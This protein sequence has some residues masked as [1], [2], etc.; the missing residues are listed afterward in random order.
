M[1]S[2]WGHI[3]VLCT[4]LCYNYCW[5]LQP[6]VQQRC[7]FSW[8]IKAY[9]GCDWDEFAATSHQNLVNPQ[10]PVVCK[11]YVIICESWS[12]L[13]VMITNLISAVPQGVFYLGRGG[14][15]G[16]EKKTS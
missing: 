9:R 16:R 6:Q 8:E 14:E 12:L 2:A 15:A 4:P 1:N 3:A 11:L 5:G 13:N 10:P 7:V